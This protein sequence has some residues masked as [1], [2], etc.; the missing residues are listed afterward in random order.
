MYNGEMI[1]ILGVFNGIEEWG[2]NVDV[3]FSNWGKC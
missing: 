1:T 2:T 3:N